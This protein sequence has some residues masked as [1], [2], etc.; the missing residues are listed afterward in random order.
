MTRRIAI[1]LAMLLCACGAR[2]AL[3]DVDGA[4]AP[5]RCNG[6]DDDGDGRVDEGIAPIR[7]GLGSCARE[8][9]GCADGTSGGCEP[10]PGSAEI[11]NGLDDDC[12]GA[13]DEGLPLTTLSDPIVLRRSGETRSGDC[14]VCDEVFGADV[15]LTRDGLAVV[16]QVGFATR[17]PRPNTFA[18]RTD[19]RGEPIEAPRLWTERST[20]YVLR[21][22]PFRAGGS[23]I[24]TCERR[25]DGRER[26]LLL[27]ADEHGAA[28]AEPIPVDTQCGP[29]GS[30][31]QVGS[32][33]EHALLLAGALELRSADGALLASR[34][35][36]LPLLLARDGGALLLGVGAEDPSG[37]RLALRMV[38]LDGRGTPIGPPALATFSADEGDV[39]GGT[40]AAAGD[41]WRVFAVLG[42]GGFGMDRQHVLTT[43][44]DRAGSAL[45]PWTDLGD[46][47][48]GVRAI[49]TS[50]GGALLFMQ[51]NALVRLDAGGTEA[52]RWEL[53]P[54]RTTE[55]SLRD[56]G[57][58]IAVVYIVDEPSALHNE[59]HLRM[60]TCGT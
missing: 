13:S 29:P 55:L 33:G 37:G 60:L 22:A 7:C 50:D 4:A 3:D 47:G 23:V 27:L 18:V 14:M 15:L 25:S 38:P 46:G 58:R 11:C 39:R 36:E 6:V 53:G 1:G 35:A 41:G 30:I 26:V 17:D 20:I 10:G 40:A 8:V 51:P 43:T 44:T 5:E 31:P 28:R 56:V 32:T 48:G 42:R 34:E 49:G 9:P 2:T 52:Q 54:L 57:G 24:A 45:G 59:L 12:D 16:W 19:L 21:A